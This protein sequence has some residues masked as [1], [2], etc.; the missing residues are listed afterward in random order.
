M[1]KHLSD[2]EASL[3]AVLDIGRGG[4]SLAIKNKD[5]DILSFLLKCTLNL[6]SADHYGSTLL[7]FACYETFQFEAEK[8]IQAISYR[9]GW[10]FGTSLSFAARKGF[11]S[12]VQAL[13]DAEAEID[14]TEPGNL[15]RSA[16]MSACVEG[17]SEIVQLCPRKAHFERLKDPGSYQLPALHKPSEMSKILNI[18][19][20]YP[21]ALS[22]IGDT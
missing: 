15:L 20:K 19:K 18:L 9:I 6:V 2:A 3:N 4:L 1:V 22:K 16:L 10:S 13:L 17:E 5:I 11:V 12:I 8:L 14:K 7:H 21:H